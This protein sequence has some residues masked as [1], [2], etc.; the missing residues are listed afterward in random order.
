MASAVLVYAI[1]AIFLQHQTEIRTLHVAIEQQRQKIFQL[2]HTAISEAIISAD[3]A[4]VKRL[5]S[6][7]SQQDQTL[8]SIKIYNASGERILNRQQDHLPERPLVTFKD[9]IIHHGQVFGRLNVSWSVDD[10]FQSLKHQE[11]QSQFLLNCILFSLAIIFITLT[12]NISL[13]LIRKTRQKLTRAATALPEDGLNKKTLNSPDIATVTLEKDSSQQLLIEAEQQKTRQKIEELSLGN[14]LFFNSSEDGIYVV[15]TSGK[16]IYVNPAVAKMTGWAVGELIGQEFNILANPVTGDLVGHS[17]TAKEPSCFPYLMDGK[18][19]HMRNA[20]LWHKDGSS[21]LVDYIS[22]PIIESSHQTSVVIV[23]KD[24]AERLKAEQQAKDIEALNQTLLSASLDATITINSLDAIVTIDRWGMICEFNPTA[25]TMFKLSKQ[26]VMGKSLVDFI[27]PPRFRDM[28]TQGVTNYLRTGESKIMRKRVE[29]VAIRSTGEEFPIDLVIAPIAV[30]NQLFFTAF[31]ND[32]T[33]RNSA[34]SDLDEALIKAEKATQAKSQFLATMSHEIRTPLN[35]IIGLN[36]LLQTTELSFEQAEYLQLA[37]QSGFALKEIIDNILDFSKIEAGKM[38]LELLATDPLSLIDSVISIMSSKAM[39]QNLELAAIITYPIPDFI[40]LD[41]V[42]IKQVLLNLVS[43]A[44]KFTKM[45]QVCI[46]LS[47][48]KNLQGK[49]TL[50]FTVKDSGAGVTKENLPFLFDEFIQIDSS[51]TRTQGGTGLGLAIAKRLVE[52]SGGEIGVNS[53]TGKGS[54]FWFSLPSV[55]DSFQ[56]TL[57]E[58]N[59]WVFDRGTPGVMGANMLYQQLKPF[60]RQIQLFATHDELQLTQESTLIFWDESQLTDFSQNEMQQFIIDKPKNCLN[61]LVS[62]N[63][64][65]L[66]Q[67]SSLHLFDRRIVKPVLN[68]NIHPFLVRCLENILGGKQP[69]EAVVYTKEIAALSGKEIR[70]LLVEDSPVNQMAI[71]VMLEKMHY[72]VDTASNGLLAVKKV[73]NDIYDLILMD[74]SMPVMGGIE[75][76]KLIKSRIGK[77]QKTPIIAL[78][79]NAFNDDKE[80]C[81]EAGMSGFLAKPI[82]MSSLHQE[83]MQYFDNTLLSVKKSSDYATEERMLADSAAIDSSVLAQLREETSDNIFPTLINIFLEQGEQRVSDIEK[84]ITENNV[85]LLEHEIHALKSESA[86]FGAF[87]LSELS[88]QI[89]LLCKQGSEKQAF[90][91]AKKIRRSWQIVATQLPKLI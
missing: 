55:N 52:M 26:D 6:E 65:D 46:Y 84:A 76:T 44:I 19:H 38:D 57:V 87:K 68:K 74:L 23:I 25:E 21:F 4:T 34:L 61:V 58:L 7:V 83:I 51:M 24:I 78:T 47:T 90:I 10:F 27:I 86:T 81:H 12:L 11:S 15:N 5:I 3:L 14:E 49:Q 36:D 13:P 91:E 75:A 22:T 54:Q 69:E 80:A 63:A 67:E 85:K 41:P 77:N 53:E 71:R 72:T 35:A 16:A 29:L 28:H 2:L 32:I 40:L 43:N 45:G 30:R 79:A 33:E 9:E 37:E 42:R 20:L 70:I 82:T 73:H 60:V 66:G 56:P 39:E 31:I 8:Y 89:N 1:F 48:Q 64:Q 62:D 59:C 17:S 18:P 50:L 88:T